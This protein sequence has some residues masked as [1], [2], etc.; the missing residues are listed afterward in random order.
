M[1]LLTF[2]AADAMWRSGFLSGDSGYN[3]RSWTD[4][5]EGP[6]GSSRK[7]NMGTFYCWAWGEYKIVK[8]IS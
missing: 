3:S 5:P 2:L 1:N 6:D 8:M 4:Y 7:Q